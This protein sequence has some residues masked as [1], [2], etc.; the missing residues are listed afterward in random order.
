LLAVS[1][2]GYNVASTKEVRPMPKAG[3]KKTGAAKPKSDTKVK[4]GDKKKDKGTKK[5]K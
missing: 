1:Q 2:S 5:K 4:K 3:G